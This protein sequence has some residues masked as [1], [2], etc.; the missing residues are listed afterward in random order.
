MLATCDEV[1]HDVSGG[2]VGHFDECLYGICVGE[3]VGVLVG[4]LVGTCVGVF[5]GVRVGV[6]VGA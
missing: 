4:F 2:F 1:L 5:V 6:H 3:K